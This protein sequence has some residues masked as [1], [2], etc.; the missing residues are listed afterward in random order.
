MA[1]MPLITSLLWIGA[2]LLLFSTFLVRHY[3]SP[4]TSLS[5]QILVTVSFALGF[6]GTTLLPI[7]LSLTGLAAV[8]DYEGEEYD[9]EYAGDDG[10]SVNETILP[11][12]ILFWSTFLLAWFILPLVREMLLSGHFQTKKRLQDGLRKMVK[13]QLILL[14]AVTIFIIAL[15]IH[16]HS[17]NVIPV[18][19]TLGNTYGILIVSLLLGYGLVALPRS[20]W[21]QAKP[22]VEL[23]RAQIMAGAADEAL[24][25][26]VWALQDCEH[27]IDLVLGTIADSSSSSSSANNDV[28]YKFCVEDLRRRKIEATTALSPELVRRKTEEYRSRSRTED[29]Y[30]EDGNGDDD[31]GGGGENG[32]TTNNNNSNIPT[33]D[34]LVQLNSEL[35]HTEERLHNA[36]QQWDALVNR[37]KFLYELSV[38][39]SRPGLVANSQLRTLGSN[40][41]YIWMKYLRSTAFRISAIATA[42][43]SIAIL[44]SE[45]T[46][47]MRNSVS[48]FA[49]VL[50]WF[51]N[52]DS[53][54]NK[55][56]PFQ[57]AAMIPLVYMS[58]CVYSSLFKLSAFGPFC[59]RG[60]RQS[61]GVALAFNAQLL[62]R[63]QFPLAYNFLQMLKYDAS[64]DTAFS[65]FMGVMKM[66]QFF[67]T[68]FPVYAPLMILAL[69]AITLLN[70]YPR[71]LSVFGFEHEDAILLGDAETLDAKV[72]EGIRLLRKH[73]EGIGSVGG[74]DRILR[75]SIV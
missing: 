59:L 25:E 75:N 56:L 13:G 12:H 48:P 37:Y 43:I 18:L 74:E 30:G 31:A 26:A 7:D 69:C 39:P 5:I 8:T 52:N 68:S 49:V 6:S 22:E 20:L 1:A 11:W 46:L 15:A 45:A 64:D 19:I 36:E 4:R 3:A 63:L 57:I 72:S 55:G 28:Y 60:N 29:E 17:L 50:G 61:S 24:F 73:V 34:R 33:L 16:Q 58:V 66:V 38:G 21:R 40:F 71:L 62:V 70:V 32:E 2:I 67:G 42:C 41:R 10:V 47:A 44:A 27:A 14:T 53:N 65:S 54:T 51:D 9:A 35:T 23:R